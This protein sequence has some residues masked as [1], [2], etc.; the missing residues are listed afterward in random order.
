M[1][2]VLSTGLTFSTKTV[3][4]FRSRRG[5]A[6]DERFHFKNALWSPDGACILTSMNESVRTL[7]RGSYGVYASGDQITAAHSIIFSP[8]GTQL[9]A[10]MDSRIVTF[11]TSRPGYDYTEM[12][13]S[14]T[15]KSRGGQKGLISSVRFSPDNS[16]LIAAASFRKEIGLYDSRSG[17]S[18]SMIRVSGAVTQVEFADPT[19]IFAASRKSD[20]ISCFDLRNTKIP[21]YDLQRPGDTNQRLYF[22][23]NHAFGNL[24]TGDNLGC[25]RVFDIQQETRNDEPQQVQTIGTQAVCGASI[26]PFYRYVAV[27]LGDR[28]EYSIDELSDEE[29]TLAPSPSFLSVWD[30]NDIAIT[31]DESEG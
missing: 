14:K 9:V 15:R 12:H 3:G 10:G 21:L 17:K 25:L 16:G 31:A 7:L 2:Q 22:S 23:I 27:A 4:D 19:Y 29:A 26:H 30:L 8:D 6:K 28:G 1:R 18:I 11:D 24:V 5:Y 20:A 13:T